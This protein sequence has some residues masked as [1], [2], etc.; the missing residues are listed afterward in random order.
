[1]IIIRQEKCWT[2]SSLCVLNCCKYFLIYFGTKCPKKIRREK[3]WPISSLHAK[4]SVSKWLDIHKE[5][6]TQNVSIFPNCIL[7][8][9]TKSITM[10][11]FFFQVFCHTKIP[12]FIGYHAIGIDSSLIFFLSAI[13]LPNFLCQVKSLTIFLYAPTI[14]KH[15]I[16]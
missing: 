1:M 12:P 4:C 15:W 9:H 8:M 5:L 6:W 13:C 3:F 2:I 7:L 11:Y 10:F 16:F 14:F